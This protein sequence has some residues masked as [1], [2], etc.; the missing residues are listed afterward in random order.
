MN[1]VG[2]DQMLAIRWNRRLGGRILV[3]HMKMDWITAK[4][5]LAEFFELD[6]LQRD[7]GVALAEL[8]LAAPMQIRIVAIRRGIRGLRGEHDISRYQRNF[9]TLIDAEISRLAG[10]KAGGRDATRSAVVSWTGIGSPKVIMTQWLRAP[11]NDDASR[12]RRMGF[13]DLHEFRFIWA[14]ACR[15]DRDPI[16]GLPRIGAFGHVAREVNRRFAAAFDRRADEMTVPALLG[17]LVCVR[18]RRLC[19]ICP[20]HSVWRNA[21]CAEQK[22]PP[23]G[24]DGNA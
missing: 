5:F 8:E 3:R 11:Q 20:A 19:E 18:T 1:A 22:Q 12:L 10:T 24:A 2:V 17:P 15:A 14:E 13:G 9:G 4:R 23:I 7:F 16:V 6:A 21:A